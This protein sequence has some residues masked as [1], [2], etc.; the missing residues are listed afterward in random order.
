MDG[1]MFIPRPL[2]FQFSPVKFVDLWGSGVLFPMLDPLNPP[3]TRRVLVHN[4]IRIE[5]PSLEFEGGI[6]VVEL[7]QNIPERAREY[8]GDL[9]VAETDFLR[10]RPQLQ[11]VDLDFDGRMETFRF[12]NRNYRSMEPDEL[13][14]YDRDID[15]T[16][17]NWDGL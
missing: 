3:L 6:E 13:W 4:S 14:N 11:R 8:V 17:E 10:G 15:Y 12:F 16:V 7:S 5:R 2:D 9:M 1:I